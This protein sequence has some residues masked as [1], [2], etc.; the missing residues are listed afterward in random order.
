MLGIALL[1]S[2]IALLLFFTS[3]FFGVFYKARPIDVLKY[4]GDRRDTE[5]IE[6]KSVKHK[7][8]L[9]RVMSKG[10]PQ[11]FLGKK[12]R[13]K[14]ELNLLRSGLLI[15]PEEFF[16]VRLILCANVGLLLYLLSKDWFI[17]ALGF[18]GSSFLPSLVI[19]SKKAK[20]LKL[21]DEQ[22]NEG[23]MIIANSLKAGYSFLQAVSLVAEETKDPFS[24]EFKKLLKEMSLGMSIE[25]SFAGMLRRVPSD[26]LR[27]VINA[28][29]IQKDIGGNLSEILNN[30]GDTIRERQK[31]QNE[32]KTLT[33]QGKMSGFIVVLLPIF[34]GLV[35]YII[36][37]SYMELMFTTSQGRVMLVVAAISQTIGIFAIKKIIQIEI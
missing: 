35:I 24:K 16:V 17:A 15:K 37:K 3:I 32:I 10:V 23:L 25:E 21:F 2:F 27:L 22:I 12:R 20:R 36:D 9:L 11:I 7:K 14:L 5:D 8:S 13:E 28:I 6:E 18:T 19:A 30:I 34:L 31:I 26:D 33:A 4:Y 1:V 29:L